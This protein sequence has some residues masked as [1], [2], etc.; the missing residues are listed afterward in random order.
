[1]RIFRVE[2]T[3]AIREASTPQPL[4]GELPALSPR[5]Q[6]TLQLMLTG[7][8]IKEIANTLQLSP[9][10]I[11]DYRKNLYDRFNVHSRAEFITRFRPLKTPIRLPEEFERQI[12][13]HDAI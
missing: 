5:L 12:R 10:T 1:M 8:S 3:R 13:L 2:L 7:L 9:H 6:Q 4:Y 11:N